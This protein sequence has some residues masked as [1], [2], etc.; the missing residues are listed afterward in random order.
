M[1][2]YVETDGGRITIPGAYARWKNAVSAQGIA[3]TGIM[4]FVGEADAGPDYSLEDDLQVNMF[5]PDQ[6][7]DVVAKYRSGPIVDAFKQAIAP[8]TDADVA[9]SFNGIIIAKANVSAKAQATMTSYTGTYGILADKSYGE[10]GNLLNFKVTAGVAKVLPTTGSFCFLP[11]IGTV[12]LEVRVDG[13]SAQP[14]SLVAA[15]SAVG[16]PPALATALGTLTGVSVLAGSGANRVLLTVAHNLVVV[17]SGTDVTVSRVT[18]G[19]AAQAWNAQPVIG[20]S[21]YIPMG[22]AIAGAANATTGAYTIKTVPTTNS[23][24]AQKIM[25]GT[26][27][28]GAT[29]VNPASVST[30]PAAAVTDVMAFAPLT[31]SCTAAG[32]PIDGVGKTIEIAAMATGTD[33]LTRCCYSPTA[34][35]AVT[36]ISTAALPAVIAGTEQQVT[37]QVV[38]S[39]DVDETFT[40]GGDLAL[41][42]SYEGNC[43]LTITSTR[44]QTTAAVSGD[45]LDLR[46]VDFPTISDLVT[47]LN[48]HSSGK[49]YAEA[50]TVALGVLPCTSL[51][52]VAQTGVSGGMGSTWGTTTARVKVD[53]YK[54][55]EQLSASTVVQ[56]GITDEP[57]RAASGL[58]KPQPTTGYTYLTGGTRG[59]TT[60]ADI[61]AAINALQD[62]DGNFVV[63]L[64]SNDAALDIIDGT[65]GPSSTYTIAVINQSVRDHVIAMKALKIRRRRQGFCSFRGS[66]ADAQAAGANQNFE[67]ITMSFMDIKASDGSDIIQYHPWMS[68]VVA[69]SLQ[70]A[71]GPKA[72]FNKALNISG[73]LQAAADYKPTRIANQESALNSGLLPLKL[74]RGLGYIFVSDQTSYCRDNNEVLNSIQAVY[75]AD[76]VT[77]SGE[78]AMQTLIGRSNATVDSTICTLKMADTLDRLKGLGW[79]AASSDAPLGYRNLKV[80]MSGG[81]VRV[82]CEVKIAQAIYFILVDFTVSS[83]TS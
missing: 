27:V 59:S 55:F 18:S 75:A 12:D 46:L 68:S 34:R 26:G 24:T 73:A 17:A 72:I 41:K 5:G 60:S 35:T 63:T 70:A 39:D 23:F 69:A 19:G 62:V 54:F 77:A 66:F 43:T 48:A 67:R 57:V 7:E 71:L 79:L 37:M 9:G 38:G 45:S 36:W 74:E 11:P 1:A 14:L 78:Q 22:S 21:V 65:T 53:A 42:L 51:D 61:T 25:N 3:S 20:D 30:T 4:M 50:G 58:P 16:L 81:V 80:T 6:L 49:Y 76:V 82:K 15:T 8:S 33:L 83:A 28:I 64:Y 31:L 56:L 10:L 2:Q 40:V 13:G 29:L 52:A 44:F 32:D 47:Y